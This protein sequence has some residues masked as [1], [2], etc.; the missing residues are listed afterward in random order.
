VTVIPVPTATLVESLL[1]LLAAAAAI[2]GVH[3]ILRRWLVALHRDRRHL[4]LSL[5]T[6]IGLSRAVVVCL[7][8]A[9][10]LVLLSLWGVRVEGV[11][12]VAVTLL[13]VVGVGFLATWTLISN[14]T[15]SLFLAIW[16]PFHLGDRVEF[17]GDPVAGRVIDRN[18]MFTTLREPAGTVLTVPNALFFQKVVRACPEGRTFVFDEFE[19]EAGAAAGS[20]PHRVP[21]VDGHA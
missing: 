2:L 3:R 14:I 7:W 10:A 5:E 15:A 1:V 19:G 9:T 18:L 13:T 11:W 17:I 8:L 20:G 6:A 12:N 16:R 21:G 4:N